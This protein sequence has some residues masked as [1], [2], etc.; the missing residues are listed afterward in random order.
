MSEGGV[1]FL[2]G[3]F[4]AALIGFVL[5]RLKVDPLVTKMEQTTNKACALEKDF[6][7]ENRKLREYKYYLDLQKRVDGRD[8]ISCLDELPKDG[9][10]VLVYGTET[11]GSGKIEERF[12][13]KFDAKQE[14][15]NQFRHIANIYKFYLEDVTHWKPLSELPIK[16]QA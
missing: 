6:Y 7:E 10:H 3:A 5:L 9:Q 2:V 4:V 11:I 12:T 1:G 8:W 15:G 16:E 13:A 14:V